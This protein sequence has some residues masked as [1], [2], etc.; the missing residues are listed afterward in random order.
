MEIRI[1][2]CSGGI[3]GA[4][5]R[6]TA[7]L[8]DSD[9]LI[10]CGTGVGDLSLDALLAVNHVFLTHAHLDHVALLPML[11]DS[12]ADQRSIPLVVYGLP[13]TLQALREH[14]F[15]WTIWPDFSSLPS[16][17]SAVLR[18]QS[19]CVGEM[20]QL[21]ERTISVLPARH[22]V[23]AVGYYLKDGR[24]GLA[25]TGDT[26]LSDELIDAL[27]ALP[28]L[29]YLVVETAFPEVM[30]S[31]AESSSH[32][33]PS[34]LRDLLLRLQVSPEV[35]ITHLK[36]MCE[37]TARDEVSALDVPLSPEALRQGQV[38]IL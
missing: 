14:I 4:G 26:G 35:Y 17:D 10:D 13:E 28:D 32:L 8:V 2:G 5:R 29:R 34:A 36:P 24:A 25:F 9:I 38:F 6:T 12:I 15:N 11:I 1:L 21:G 16:A 30:R 18:F 37:A 19:I 33:Y 22:S 7:L 23:P 20:I 31:K 3:G 27:N